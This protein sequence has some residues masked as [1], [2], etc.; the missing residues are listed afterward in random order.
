MYL[1]ETKANNMDNK[2]KFSYKI[3]S[4]YTIAKNCCDVSD[5][6]FGLNELKEFIKQNNHVSCRLAY[7]KIISL[8]NKL[9]KLTSK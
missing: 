7:K 5:I 9:N 8:E 4:A 1:C 2:L 6:N 3:L